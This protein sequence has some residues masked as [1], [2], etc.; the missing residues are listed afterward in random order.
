MSK[1]VVIG[2]SNTDMVIK[3][4]KFPVPGETILGGEFFMFSGGKGAN[5]AVAAARM[6]AEVILICKTGND[7]FGQR[8]IDEFK[9]EGI[10]T[11]YIQKD[12]NTAS[13]TA[14][15]LVDDNG[16]NEI[17]VAPG[18]NETLT[19]IEIQAAEKVIAGATILLLQ[20]EI[21]VNSV[22]FAAK[23]GYEAGT[24]VILNPAPAQKL[25][26]EI[27]PCLYLVTP[28]ETEAEILTGIKVSDLA[29]ASKAAVVLLQAG[30]Q[31]VIITL[32]AQGAF[33]KNEN[34]EMLVKA[35]VV[36]AIDTTAAGD[37]FNGVLAVEITSGAAWEAAISIAC[38]AAAV[39]V[40][41]MGA[42]ASMPYRKEVEDL[43]L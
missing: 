40:T 33:F 37:V 12:N 17:V 28:N 15:I 32:G 21:P 35:P 8:A 3:T 1:I 41:R 29:S 9:K 16:E 34:I 24:K 10:I 2:S 7:I 36:K 20:L 31:N 18:A 26:D 25:P 30:V 5:Q 19:A 11:A 22:L 14:L 27:F 23:K 13:G 39:S 43:V 6:G 42:Q 38:K 4:S